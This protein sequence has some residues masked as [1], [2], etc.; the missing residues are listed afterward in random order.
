V[1]DLRGVLDESSS[2]A[3]PRAF[4]SFA[5]RAFAVGGFGVGSKDFSVGG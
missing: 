2:K 4:V 5:R 1:P 3:S